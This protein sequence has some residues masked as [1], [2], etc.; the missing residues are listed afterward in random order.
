MRC[1]LLRAYNEDTVEVLRFRAYGL[2]SLLL[3]VCREAAACR[4]CGCGHHLPSLSGGQLKA[5]VKKHP[6]GVHRSSTGERTRQSSRATSKE[7]SIL[8]I[9][10][11]T[12]F[13]FCTLQVQL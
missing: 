5:S 7:A 6:D 1:L 11:A 13:T 8:K 12:T 9:S 3:L 2:E 10:S 4:V